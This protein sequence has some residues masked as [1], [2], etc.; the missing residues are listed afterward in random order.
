MDIQDGEKSQ[1]GKFWKLN[2]EKSVEEAVDKSE[3]Q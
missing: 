1:W 3:V 2:L